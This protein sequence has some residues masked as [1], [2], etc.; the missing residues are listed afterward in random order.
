MR[1]DVGQTLPKLD[2][3]NYPGDRFAQG[4]AE[5]SAAGLADSRQACLSPFLRTVM[6]QLAH[7]GAGGQEHEI[8]VAGLALAAPELTLA[9]AQMLLPVPMEGLRSCPALA[10]GLENT[11]HFPTGAVGNQNLAW[12]GIP[13]ASPQHHNPHRVIDARNANALGEVPLLLAVHGRFPPAERPEF[14]LHPLTRFPLASID[15]D[16]AIKLQVAD[17]I[18]ALAV[19]VVDDL[20]VG[21]V[22]VEREIALNSP[23]D[24]PIDQLFAQEGV[25]LEGR[26]IGNTGFLFPKAAELQ[27]VVLARSTDVVGNQVVVSD[28]VPLVTGFPEPPTIT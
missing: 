13:L 10:V 8:H 7:Q 11:M 9:H 17:V 4:F 18:A 20:S 1:L 23:I 21:E 22:A 24:D 26:P 27:G 3:L 14:G 5:H 12:F 28:Q 6:P 15:A 2:L 16:G 19:D 25:I